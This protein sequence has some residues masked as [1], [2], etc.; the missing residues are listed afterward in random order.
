MK[1]V[2]ILDSLRAFAAISVCL[3]H[4]ICTTIGLFS[5]STFTFIF[6]YG[7]YGVHVFF[8]ISGFIIPYAMYYSNY[9]LKALPK[10]ILKRLTRLEPPYIFSIILILG[11][12][13]LKSKFNI[14]I[15]DRE[16]ITMQRVALHFGY[17]INFTKDYKWFN[18]VYWTL[19][20]EF[21]YYIIIGF[22][23]VLFISKKTIIRFLAYA[24]FFLM[25]YVFFIYR[26]NGHFP[27]YAPLFLIGIITF[28]F[29]IKQIST[30]EFIILFILG[31]IYNFIYL[32]PVVA[33]LGMVTSLIILFYSNK[34]I[35]VLNFFGKMSYSIYLIHPIIGAAVINLLSRHVN[36]NLQKIGIVGL[37]LLVT[38]ICSYFMYLIIEMPSKKLSSKIKL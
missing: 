25:G 10:F 2:S 6:T 9:N 21:Q 28:L 1:H 8:I 20:I 29:K 19:A 14:G 26:L 4:F 7:K 36:T 31:F 24:I 17:L 16:P 23:Y 35:I 3:Y 34:K 18:N 27:Y 37:G 5:V 32:E 33:F 22:L 13:F 30:I 12:I 11:I 15:E 38:L